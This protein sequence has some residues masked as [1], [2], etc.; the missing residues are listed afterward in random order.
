MP[1]MTVH[2][3]I[4]VAHR[5]LTLPGKCQNIHGHSMKVA[6]KVHGDLDP[7]GYLISFASKSLIDFGSLKK[8][9]RGHLDEKYDHHLL[10]NEKD[11]FAEVLVPRDLDGV[12]AQHLPGL[13]PCPGDPSTENIAL[14]IAQHMANALDQDVEVTI[15][16]TGTNEISVGAD[17]S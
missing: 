4:E 1:S 5:L 17:P 3:N 13:V 9:F 6:L 14:W 10:L 11:P 15:N 8:T 7:D 16:E 12:V 2:H